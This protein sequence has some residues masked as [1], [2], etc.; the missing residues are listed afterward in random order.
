LTTAAGR[1]G[2]RIQEVTTCGADGE[3]ETAIVVPAFRSAGHASCR[4]QPGAQEKS[5]RGK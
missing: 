3:K 1:I 5:T 2:R 4:G